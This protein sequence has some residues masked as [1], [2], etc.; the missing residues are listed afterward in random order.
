MHNR[1][2][3]EAPSVSPPNMPVGE[4]R[5]QIRRRRVSNRT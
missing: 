5:E 1:E 4:G 3:E 2:T